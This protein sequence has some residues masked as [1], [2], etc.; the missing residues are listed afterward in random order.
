MQVFLE[1]AFWFAGNRIF[2]IE[3]A[4]NLK[5]SLSKPKFTSPVKSMALQY[6]SPQLLH[7]SDTG[8]EP[9]SFNAKMMNVK[10]INKKCLLS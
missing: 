7:N 9:I 8:P 3:K 5:P 10:K 6:F 1:E 2:E 4:V